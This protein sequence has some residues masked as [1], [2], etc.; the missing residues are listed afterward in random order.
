MHFHKW[1]CLNFDSYYT[2][3]Y[4]EG[5]NWW[6]ANIS[7]ENGMA[8]NRRQDGFWTSFFHIPNGRREVAS[9]TVKQSN[10]DKF[11]YCNIPRTSTSLSFRDY[12]KF[13]DIF[14]YLLAKL[15]F[16]FWKVSFVVMLK[17]FVVTGGTTCCR[18]RVSWW[19]LMVPPRSGAA[20]DE[21]CHM[22]LPGPICLC[23]NW[24]YDDSRFLVECKPFLV[25][26]VG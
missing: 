22:L 6:Y 4:S 16:M 19:Q 18:S 5:S 15:I 10:L 20:S 9:W 1:K 3:V 23:D 21:V 13:V 7:S 26:T 25:H 17:S 24:H 8:P 2:D 11:P 12:Y 14:P